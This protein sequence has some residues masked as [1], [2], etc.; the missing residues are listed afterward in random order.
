MRASFET[1]VLPCVAI[2]AESVAKSVK[3]GAIGA[4]TVAAAILG[5]EA[6]ASEVIAIGACGARGV[7]ETGAAV[8]LATEI[9]II[10]VKATGAGEKAVAAAVTVAGGGVAA[11]AAGLVEVEGASGVVAAVAVAAA[12]AAG[13]IIL[14]VGKRVIDALE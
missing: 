13:A 2:V 3:A 14:E 6:V 8:F 1:E 7:I 11:V 12:G 5:A 10:G 9:L 4:I